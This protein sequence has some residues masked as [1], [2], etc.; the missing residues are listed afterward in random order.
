[1]SGLDKMSRAL[2][3]VVAVFLLQVARIAKCNIRCNVT[4]VGGPQV[5]NTERQNE[6][7]NRF[8]VVS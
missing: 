1:M 6:L 5:I 4:G 8:D 2:H 3:L 7:H